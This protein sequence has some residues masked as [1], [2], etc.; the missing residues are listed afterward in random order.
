MGGRTGGRA[1]GRA[2]R[3]AAGGQAG[4]QG[5]RQVQSAAAAQVTRH[6]QRPAQCIHPV[7]WPSALQAPK[8]PTTQTPQPPAPR[9]SGNTPKLAAWP[10]WAPAGS[11][12]NRSPACKGVS[13]W[14]SAAAVDRTC[15]VSCPP[16]LTTRLDPGL[17][18]LACT[19][20]PGLAANVA[21][22]RRPPPASAPAA[23]PAHRL[24]AAELPE[25]AARAFIC[26]SQAQTSADRARS[27]PQ[28]RSSSARM[29]AGLYRRR[30]H[31]CLQSMRNTSSAR[32]SAQVPQVPTLV[33]REEFR[34]PLAADRSSPA[35]L[36]RRSSC[37]FVGSLLCECD[38][39]VRLLLLLRLP[40]SRP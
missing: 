17:V 13:G 40:I 3:R 25:P 31:R 12:A 1:G 18:S 15:T 20:L 38:G 36:I 27:G 9:T 14:P 24:A 4:R 7:W 19:M 6:R 30:P 26:C 21:G 35:D 11:W 8:V 37:R 2:G 29:V 10:S 5:G 23:A 39:H 33:R 34:T 22:G 32:S 16:R 28:G